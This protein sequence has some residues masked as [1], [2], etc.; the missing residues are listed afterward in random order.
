MRFNVS[1]FQYDPQ[2]ESD[3]WEK[4]VRDFEVK[5]AMDGF[6]EEHFVS[7]LE[8]GC[9]S[10][11]HSKRLA[12]Y[13]KKLI[14]MEYNEERLFEKSSGKISFILGDAQ[15]L[16]RFD[17][18]AFDLV[19]SSNLIEHLPNIDGCISECARV[20]NDEG[21]IIHMVPNRTWK[22][23]NLGL[24]YPYLIK[25]LLG[26]AL[27]R[28][29]TSESGPA[30]ASEAQLDMNLNPLQERPFLHKF[31]PGKPHGISAS[32]W[33]EYSVWGEK[34]WINIFERNGLEVV[35][36]IRQPFYAGYESDFN[37]LLRLGNYFGWSACTGY[38]L[39]K[40]QR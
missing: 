28:F 38:I 29:N 9:G 39:K 22:T 25:T 30:N 17:D 26:R 34:H 13:C 40:A 23:F 31:I 33:R 6:A 20:S 1:Q 21:V 27:S 7:G 18:A 14:A 2:G 32:H 11:R 8:L 24:Y 12:H 16:S 19:F 36:I 10:G 5:K 37:L 15:D 35:K 4:F 3:Q